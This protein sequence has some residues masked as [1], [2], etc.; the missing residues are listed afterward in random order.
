MS[1]LHMYHILS[2][3]GVLHLDYMILNFIYYSKRF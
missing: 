1:S 3:S 2:I